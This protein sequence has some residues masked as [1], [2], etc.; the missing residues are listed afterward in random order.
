MSTH[1]CSIPYGQASFRDIRRAG[2]AYVDK[3]QVIESLERLNLRFA[4]FLRPRR[5]GKTLLASMLKEYYDRSS[6]KDFDDLFAG[7]YIH[8]HKTSDQGDYYVLRLDF[9]G[10]SAKS[11]EKSFMLKLLNGMDDFFLRYPIPGSDEIVSGHFDDPSQLMEAFFLKVRKVVGNRLFLIIDEYDQF[12][13]EILASDSRLFLKITSNDG[14]LK[15]FYSVLKGEASGGVL[16]RI[17]MTGV[18][19]L[20]VDS[21]S[22]GFGIQLNIS[23][24]PI[25]ADAAGFTERELRALIRRTLDLPALGLTEEE[26]IERMHDYYNGYRFSPQSDLSVYNSSMC[27]HYLAAF[28]MTGEEPLS[29][30]DPSVGVDINK[31]SRIL[32]LADE[33]A[34]RNVVTATVEDRPVFL[35]GAALSGPINLNNA[36]RLDE[37][38]MLA[39][40]F[41]M[42]YLTFAPESRS[43]LRCPNKAM[44]SQ[45]FEYFFQ[46]FYGAAPSFEG[47]DLQR[48]FHDVSLGDVVPLLKF[49]SGKLVEAG[50]LH[51]LTHFS[52]TSIQVAVKFA[53]LPNFH[54]EV[55]LEDEARGQGF[56]DLLLRPKA[57]NPGAAH[58]IE[59]KQIKKS[60]GSEAEV[61]RALLRAVDQLRRY[62]KTEPV[63][64]LAH[65]R[66]WA[67]VFVGLE[68]REVASVPED[69]SAVVSKIQ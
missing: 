38:G 50:G 56:C 5:F 2:A 27:L 29:I 32:S 63:R 15:N 42:G 49:I 48:I 19:S 61:R 28:Q 20:S 22:S 44:K 23:Q 3:T 66:K 26:L 14:F 46:A 57:G 10:M 67:A 58:L 40:L 17:F 21:V 59:L 54:Y 7:T 25:F 1:Y 24:L 53:M 39:V 35:P 68:L 4:L 64:S 45:F 13:N 60:A 9:S 11:V 41:F 69:G 65:C 47:P 6:A 33:R 62:A 34:V 37:R 55:T 52:E 31:V 16:S 12:A 8:S 36:F 18:T 43:E 30:F 51:L